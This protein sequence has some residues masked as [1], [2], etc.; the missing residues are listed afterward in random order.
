MPFVSHY[1]NM[2]PN[3]VKVIKIFIAIHTVSFTNY[4]NIAVTA[5]SCKS[6]PVSCLMLSHTLQC[7]SQHTP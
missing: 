7:S 1:G 6:D 4:G 5:V 3:V 2:M